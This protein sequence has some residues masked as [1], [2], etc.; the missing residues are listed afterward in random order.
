MRYLV[1]ALFVSILISSCTQ[2]PSYIKNEGYVFGT[3]Y[4]FTYESKTNY[5]PE[6]KALL[7]EFNRSLS[8]YDPNSIISRINKNDTLV[9]ADS[10][11]I[12]CFEKSMEISKLTDG[13][14]DLTVA[15]VVNA[16]G[17]GFD[18]SKK[19]DSALIDSLMH[20]VGY[21]KVVL[22]NKKI[23]KQFTGTMLD[24]SAVAKGQGV[25]VAANYLE[26]QGIQNYMVEIGGEVRVKGINASGS[27]WKIGIDKPIE[28][29]TASNRELQDVILLT[30]KSMATSGNYRQ[31]Y[32]KDGVIY[33]HT[34]NPKTGYP[35]RNSLLSTSVIADDCMTAD[36]FATAFMVM[37]I[38]K[39]IALSKELDYLDVYFIYADSLNTLQVYASE[40]FKNLIAK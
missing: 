29:P 31:F 11:F 3:T 23:I 26:K 25:D 21:E 20:F 40:P 14:F 36:A 24:A 35:A 17:F 33:S 39:S 16:W 8:T 38:D 30:N 5:E 6:L 9:V 28:D 22:K 15:P 12:Q 34:I 37:G 2:K 19:A 1:I 18:E 13:A 27:L 4:H 10:F 32:E 7:N